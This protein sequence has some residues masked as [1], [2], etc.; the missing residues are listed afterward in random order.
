MTSAETLDR[1]DGGCHCG[2]VTIAVS[3]R[4]EYL[5]ACNCSVCTK[6]G[7]MW[8][9]YTADEVTVAG[10]ARDY[11]RGD[12]AEPKLVFHSCPN[13]GSTTHYTMIESGPA[14]KVGVNMRTFDPA[15]LIGVELRFGDRRNY[16][17]GERQYYRA[18]CAFDGIGAKA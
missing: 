15:W 14:T 18:P 9:Y 13:C 10:A 16:P 8:G 5:N 4:P 12:V 17:S 1:A 6:L 3:R 11:V 2:R 7:A